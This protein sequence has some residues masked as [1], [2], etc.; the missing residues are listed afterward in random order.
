[1]KPPKFFIIILILLIITFAIAGL[2]WL[3]GDEDNWLCQNGQWI[4]HGNPS[5]PQPN[6]ACK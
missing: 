1:M 4:K 2:M 6:T 5:L 3:R